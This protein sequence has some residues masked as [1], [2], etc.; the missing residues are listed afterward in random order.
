MRRKACPLSLA[1]METGLY[2]IGMLYLAFSVVAIFNLFM[3]PR[4]RRRR[5]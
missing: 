5:S 2:I 1:A 3:L 4:A